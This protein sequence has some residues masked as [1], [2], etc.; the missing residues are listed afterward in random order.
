LA[1]VL[2]SLIRGYV[3][4]RTSEDMRSA[5]VALGAGVG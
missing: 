4:S 2:A 5:P 1:Q 3:A